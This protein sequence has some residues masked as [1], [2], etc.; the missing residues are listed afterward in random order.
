MSTQKVHTQGHSSIIPNGPKAKSTQMSTDWGT[1]AEMWSS[2][3]VEYSSAL[4]M[5]QSSDPYHRMTSLEN[6]MPSERRQAQKG[7]CLV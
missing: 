5:E 6:V 7:T 2:H 1:E 4:K 3:T